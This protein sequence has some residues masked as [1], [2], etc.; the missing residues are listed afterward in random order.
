MPIPPE[1]NESIKRPNEDLEIQDN[2]SS[3]AIISINIFTKMVTEKVT[4]HNKGLHA[5]ECSFYNR[6]LS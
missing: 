1:K 4:A 3:L 2:S 6:V 5:L